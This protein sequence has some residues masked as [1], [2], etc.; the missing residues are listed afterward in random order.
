M[1]REDRIMNNSDRMADPAFFSRQVF[2]AR[3]FHLPLPSRGEGG[4]LAVVCGGCEHCAAD[5]RID[6]KTFPYWCLELV[7]QGRGAVRA[8]GAAQPLRAG[9]VFVYGPGIAYRME[10]DPDAPLVKYFADFSGPRA[11]ALLRELGFVP[12]RAASVFPPGEAGEAFDRLIDAGLGGSARAPRRAALLLEALLLGCADARVSAGEAGTRAF[13]TYRR[14]RDVLDGLDPAGETIR[15]AAATARACHI[16]GAYLCRLFRRFARCTAHAHLA[17]L[18]M[19]AA[20]ARLVQSG[21]LV[22]EVA[23][24]FGFADPYH[25]SR[26]FKQFHRVAPAEFI[27]RRRE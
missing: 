1:D 24:E 8:G 12:G 19:A 6:R 22:K 3:R 2:R 14:C 26:A 5:Y 27:R 18:R 23:A 21:V 25:F 10:S 15:S 13:A 9:S 7:V 20:T 16:D 17:R 11:R 4:G